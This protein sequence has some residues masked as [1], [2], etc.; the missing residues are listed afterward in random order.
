MREIAMIMVL[1]EVGKACKE[2]WNR[3]VDKESRNMCACVNVCVR[4]CMCAGY[5]V[6]L[7][8]QWSNDIAHIQ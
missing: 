6:H 7:S 5:S 8:N 1:A 2:G 3:H 4:V